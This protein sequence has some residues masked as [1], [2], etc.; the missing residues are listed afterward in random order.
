MPELPEVESVR[1]GVDEWTAGALI[2]G[3]EVVDPRILGTKIG[4]HADEGG[5][6]VTEADEAASPE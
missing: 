6:G 5:E 4:K 3:A 1:R 2:T